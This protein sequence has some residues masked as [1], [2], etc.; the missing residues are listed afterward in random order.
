[1]YP[2]VA[3]VYAGF[4]SERKCPRWREWRRLK[5]PCLRSGSAAGG[6]NVGERDFGVGVFRHGIN[7]GTPYRAF[8]FEKGRNLLSASMILRLRGILRRMQGTDP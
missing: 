1:M 2:L 3:V 8:V 6:V 4:R 5:S 7:Q